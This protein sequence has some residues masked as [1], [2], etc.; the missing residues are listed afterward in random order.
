MKKILYLFLT[1]SL[2][3]SS[4]KKEED[5]VV[6][7]TVISGCTDSDATNYNASATNDDGLCEYDITGVWETTS[8]VLNGD[9]LMGGP[10]TAVELYYFFTDGTLGTENYDESGNLWAYGE[11]NINSITSFPNSMT[12]SGT[13]YNLTDGTEQEILGLNANVDNLTNANNMTWRFTNY[14]SAADT[15]VKTLVRS[16]AFSLSDWK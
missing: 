4:C 7:P 11:W 14:P 12:I 1:V 9:E 15:Y 3:F 6:T 16:T 13:V 10:L 2:I 5:E 8:S